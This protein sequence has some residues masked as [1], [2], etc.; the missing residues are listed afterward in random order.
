M[1]YC[2]CAVEVKQSLSAVDA[3]D[4]VG[5]GG[6]KKKNNPLR[7]QVLYSGQSVHLR[8][9][10]LF[11]R[12]VIKAEE[13]AGIVP[14]TWQVLSSHLNNTSVSEQSVLW[15]Q[16]WDLWVFFKATSCQ[17]QGRG[18]ATWG[19]SVPVSAP[20][21]SITFSLRLHATSSHWCSARSTP[22]QRS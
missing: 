1:I 17:W 14:T 10:V 20:L 7:C 18:V 13:E 6:K 8:S 4:Q 16:Q 5:S 12:W 19:S 9:S 22:S 3:P 2:T 21:S 15:C 11:Y